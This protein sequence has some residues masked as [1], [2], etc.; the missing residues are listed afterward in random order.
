MTSSTSVQPKLNW[1]ENDLDLETEEIPETQ[2][3]QAHRLAFKSHN[4][5]VTFADHLSQLLFTYLRVFVDSGCFD[6]VLVSIFDDFLILVKGCR[7]TEISF[8][9]IEAVQFTVRG[10]PCRPQEKP[11]AKQKKQKAV[12]RKPAATAKTF[13]PE[14]LRNL[15][16]QD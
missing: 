14:L 1:W 5:P 13:A 11:P 2:E 16:A 3:V 8:K 10:C 6:G 4:H 12:K 15:F 9:E 7:I